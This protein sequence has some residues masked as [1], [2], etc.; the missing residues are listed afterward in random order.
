MS[1]DS[2]GFARGPARSRRHPRVAVPE[3]HSEAAIL[4]IGIWKLLHL[5]FA[6]SYVGALV[7]ADWNGR[8]A[9]ATPDWPQRAL[10]FDICRISSGLAGF[11]SLIGLGVL[12]NVLAARAGYGMRSS[13]M[14]SVNLLWLA[15]LAVM[16][17]LTRPSIAK[18]T[19][20][21]RGAVA[22]ET[23]EGYAG[24]LSRW[25]LGNVLASALYLVLLV[26]MVFRWKD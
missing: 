13:W 19:V 15:A 23:P 25:R 11:G 22:G 10:L 26:L 6:F 17:F 20:L 5:F 2:A 21:A 3:F 18:L 16:A 14:M 9:R 12:G 7:V 4:S 8:A 24:A 1:L